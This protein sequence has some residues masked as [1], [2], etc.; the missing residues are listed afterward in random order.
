MQLIKFI[1]LETNLRLNYKKYRH[2]LPY[3]V[4]TR[5]VIFKCKLIKY[6]TFKLSQKVLLIALMHFLPPTQL[7]SVLNCLCSQYLLKFFNIYLLQFY[8][9]LS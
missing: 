8:V 3:K 6:K 7:S 9:V 5:D 2:A 1:F 4:A